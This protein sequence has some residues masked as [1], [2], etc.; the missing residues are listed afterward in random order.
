MNVIAITSWRMV[1]K[2]GG[3]HSHTIEKAMKKRSTI[4]SRKILV[5]WR[6]VDN[7]VHGGYTHCG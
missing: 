2:T 5:D 6:I 7:T 3:N 4:Y 1:H